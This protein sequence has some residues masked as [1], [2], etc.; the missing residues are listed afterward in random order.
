MEPSGPTLGELLRRYRRR[1]AIRNPEL[2]DRLG[3]TVS[4]L[5]R[6]LAD[7]SVDLRMSVA[8]RTAELL[9]LNLEDIDRAL[10]QGRRERN[11]EVVPAARR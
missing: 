10:A 6:L 11:T 4:T 7:R 5:S 1:E 3:V 8:T 9:R 2:A